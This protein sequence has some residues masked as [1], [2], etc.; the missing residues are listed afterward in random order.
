MP[1]RP[2]DT[3]NPLPKTG[4]KNAALDNQGKVLHPVAFKVTPTRLT[5]DPDVKKNAQCQGKPTDNEEDESSC[6]GLEKVVDSDEQS[7]DHTL[8][9]QMSG[10]TG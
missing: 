7:S 6:W 2:S 10:S 8:T 3:T 5:S 1:I 4:S 9:K